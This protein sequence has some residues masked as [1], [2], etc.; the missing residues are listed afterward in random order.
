MGAINFLD[1]NAG[2]IINPD[3]AA[4]RRSE[5]I[6]WE[7]PPSGPPDPLAGYPPHLGSMM[8]LLMRGHRGPPPPPSWSSDPLAR[9]VIGDTGMTGIVDPYTR[10]HTAVTP[11]DWQ[12]MIG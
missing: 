7:P 1:P 9:T 6:P 12:G 11:P 5:Y 2:T 3:E 8:Q 10:Q 4:G